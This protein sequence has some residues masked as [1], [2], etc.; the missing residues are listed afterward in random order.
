MEPPVGRRRHRQRS[1]GASPDRRSPCK[2][3][4]WIGFSTSPSWAPAKHGELYITRASGR[5][6]VASER[7]VVCGGLS[8]VMEPQCGGA[9]ESGAS[10]AR[11]A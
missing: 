8:G 10:P 3:I 7:I 5:A 4:A 6:L 2:G 9:T 11:P 1:H